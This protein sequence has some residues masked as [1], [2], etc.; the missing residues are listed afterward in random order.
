MDNIAQDFEKEFAA[1]E[2]VATQ[3]E[4]EWPL[5]KPL[6]NQLMV[7][8][9]RGLRAPSDTVRI[10]N[11]VVMQWKN[12][13][14]DRKIEEVEVEALNGK[15]TCCKFKP[16]KD[17]KGEGKGLIQMPEKIKLA[18]QTRRGELVMVKPVIE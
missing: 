7:A 13:Y 14:A 4:P 11:A 18:L 2:N 12:Q 16:T 10:D 5:P 3:T 6:V 17:S 15:T 1:E 8:T 9:L